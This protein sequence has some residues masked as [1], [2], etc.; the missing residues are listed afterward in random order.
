MSGVVEIPLA[1][2]YVAIVDAAD[3]DR[4]L[5]YKWSPKPHGRTVYAHRSVRKPDGTR[6]KQ[7]LHKFLTGYERTDHRNGNGLD[8]RRSNLRESTAGQN[9]QNRR[10]RRDNTSGFKGVSW[11]KRASRWH[12]HIAVNGGNQQ[13][14]GYFATAEEAARAYDEAARELHGEFAIVN[15]PKS[16]ERAA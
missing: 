2:G 3:A 15:F 4:V 1:S 10:Q 12:A 8:N 11:Y 14:L 16:G 9:S 13:T 7:T 6:T 5:L